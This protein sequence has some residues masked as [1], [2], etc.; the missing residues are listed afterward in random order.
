M[1]TLSFSPRILVVDDEEE[2]CAMISRRF[3]MLGHDIVTET[4]PLKVVPRLASENILIVISDVVMPEMSG[5]DLLKEIKQFNGLI[6][7]IMMTGHVRQ[8]YA[9][10]CMRRG[11]MTMLFKPLEDLDILE[12]TVDEALAHLRRWEDIF[13]QL[14]QLPKSA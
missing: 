6:Q 4:N 3:R 7:V 11:A 5:V 13:L 9:M 8:E 12:E 1:S 10:D 14:R 2:I